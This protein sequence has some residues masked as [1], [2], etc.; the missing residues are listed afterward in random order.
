MEPFL[1]HHFGNPSS[2]HVFGAPCTDAVKLARARLA[3]L[4]GCNTAEI[5]FTACGSESDN[6]A[7]V[8]P[9]FPKSM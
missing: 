1:W 4:L 3:T 8:V 2:A 9:I 7:V 5:V 6:F